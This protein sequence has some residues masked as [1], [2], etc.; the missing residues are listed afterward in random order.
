[1]AR[2]AGEA[3]TLQRI[4]QEATSLFVARGYEGVSMRE[5][6]EAVGITKAALYYHFQDKEDLFMAILN[7]SLEEISGVLDRAEAAGQDARGRIEETVRGLLALPAER[8]ALIRVASQEM[9]H[10]RPEVRAAFN[11]VYQRKFVG[12]IA[13]MLDDGMRRGELRAMDPQL[14]AWLLLGMAYPF[15]QPA[16]GAQP[17]KEIGETLV[18]VFFEGMGTTKKPGF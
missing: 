18:G 2:E 16:H 8:R 13:G 14:G 6:G 12:R 7:A 9:V 15:F 3:D 10:V 17:I 11:E 5:I 4:L 1:M